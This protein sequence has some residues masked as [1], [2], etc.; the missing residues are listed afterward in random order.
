MDELIKVYGMGDQYPT[1]F[2]QHE[3][4]RFRELESCRAYHRLFTRCMTIISN[5]DY[6]D[7]E[8]L[9]VCSHSPE[10]HK[11]TMTAE[12]PCS[13]IDWDEYGSVYCECEGYTKPA[14]L[15]VIV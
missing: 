11:G 4:R 13:H 10:D 6:D 9:I 3:M 2:T 7:N 15:M 14:P 1:Y 8:I 12:S 5:W